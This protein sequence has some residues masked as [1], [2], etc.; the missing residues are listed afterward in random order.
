MAPTGCDLSDSHPY[1]APEVIHALVQWAYSRMSPAKVHSYLPIL[2]ARRVSGNTGRPTAPPLWH[3]P[4]R[5]AVVPQAGG[6][7]C[8]EPVV[9][10]DEPNHVG[11]GVCLP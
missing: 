9:A 2:V 3:L 4:K 10:H 6:S 7:D 11:G 5:G 1:V 8:A